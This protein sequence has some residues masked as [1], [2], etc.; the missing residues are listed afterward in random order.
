M[1][2][3]ASHRFAESP[4]VMTRLPER[5]ETY[6]TTVRGMCRRCRSVA[7]ARVF[8]RDSQVWQQ[9]LCPCSPHEPALIAGHVGWYL[10]ECLR[11]RP[12]RSPLPGAHPPQQGCPHDCGPCTWHATPCQLPV[13]SI[14]NACNLRCPICFTYNRP[15]RLYHMPV[16]ELRRTVDWIIESSG[17][18]DLI[19][20]TGGEPTLH[21]DLLDL[22]RVCRRPEIGRVTV[23]SNGIRL[24]EDLALCQ[25][26]A[27]VGAYVILSLNTLDAETSCRMH[28]VDLVTTKLRAIENLSRAGVRMT[29]LCVLARGVNERD[30]PKL[31]ELLCQQENVLSLT[32]QT[33]TYTGQGGGDFPRAQQ[34]PVD[35]AARLVCQ[36]S[37]GLLRP[38]HFVTRPSAH[39]LCYLVCYM[40]KSGD[41]MLPFARF[42]PRERISAL[43]ADS[44]LVRATPD[45]E[46]FVDAVNRLYA[47][48]QTEH[49]AKLRRL[50][51]ALY[52]PDRALDA[53]QRQRIA[54][55]GVR[56]VYLHAHMDEDTF[57]CSRALLCPDLVPAEPGRLIPACT[58][59]LFY[60][61]QD[62]R[63][64]LRRQGRSQVGWDSVPTG[65]GQSPNLRKC[66]Q[67]SISRQVNDVGGEN[68]TC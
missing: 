31:F 59:N 34:I 27:D 32:I 56:T 1:P 38:D 54:E 19:N 47:D 23:N 44:Y 7:P 64:F 6:F 43:L 16:A 4:C 63:F 25:Q 50:V 14:T 36:H 55:A 11:A 5:A 39:P 66:T 3:D 2:P 57:D 35:E 21:P 46:F 17:P 13:L 18:V 52:P 26:L 10:S 15:D 60:R 30:L 33:M 68:P 24:A 12:D 8:F 65:S 53:F 20:I 61:R 22:L 49:L 62:E 58:Y 45:D 67:N 41:Q 29:L 37:G 42:A 51:E 40:L 28:G 48:G 9:S